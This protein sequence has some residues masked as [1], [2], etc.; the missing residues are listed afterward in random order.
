MVIAQQWLCT[1]DR[2]R[3][4]V[5]QARPAAGRPPERVVCGTGLSQVRSFSPS[6]SQV[7]SH[8]LL[9]GGCKPL[10]LLSLPASADRSDPSVEVLWL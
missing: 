10:I 7:E 8:H 3:G 5:P 1:G 4:R 9:F 6:P 2:A